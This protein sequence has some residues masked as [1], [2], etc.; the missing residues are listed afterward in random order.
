MKYPPASPPTR[1]FISSRALT[2][3]Q[4]AEAIRGHWAFENRRHWV[5]DVSFAADQSRLHQ[6]KSAA[7]VLDPYQIV[8][9]AVV[10]HPDLYG[11]GAA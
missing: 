11:V 3:A 8:C 6:L 5:L 10:E 2:A 4:S 9:L 1:Y 7:V